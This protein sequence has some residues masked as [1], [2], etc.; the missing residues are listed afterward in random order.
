MIAFHDFNGAKASFL[1]AIKL[2]RDAILIKNFNTLLSSFKNENYIGDAY[3]EFRKA[4][5]AE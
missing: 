3:D 2:S 1:K 5:T 4:Q